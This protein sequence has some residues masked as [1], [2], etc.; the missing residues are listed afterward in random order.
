MAVAKVLME[1]VAHL[2]RRAGGIAVVAKGVTANVKEL[3]GQK[4]PDDGPGWER[5][6]PKDGLKVELVVENEAGGFESA[7]VV[8][9]VVGRVVDAAR[10]WDSCEFQTVEYGAGE[11]SGQ[12]VKKAVIRPAPV[13]EAETSGGD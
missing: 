7:R 1:L 2:L 3:V 4:T 8:E 12:E 10:E 9:K 13:D 11:D 6:I 5:L